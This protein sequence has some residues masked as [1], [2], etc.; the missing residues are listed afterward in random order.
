VHTNV[1]ARLHT[2]G[3][4]CFSEAS[5][6]QYQMV[7]ERL[8]AAL[9]G[10]FALVALVLPGMGL[11]GVL[12]Y[13]VIQRRHQIAF[14]SRWALVPV[15][16]SAVSITTNLFVMISLGAIIGL[17]GELAC[18]R[19]VDTLLFEV[20][21]TD[22]GIVLGSIIFYRRGLPLLSGS[23]MR[24]TPFRNESARIEPLGQESCQ[25]AYR[26]ATR[27]GG[28]PKKPPAF[29][30]RSRHSAATQRHQADYAACDPSHRDAHYNSC[31]RRTHDARA[32]LTLNKS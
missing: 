32:G 3:V 29:M 28:S 1:R 26:C 15:T 22:P 8:L 5:V 31:A 11:Y 2:A 7:R 14:A 30:W 4:E 13:A 12:R 24:Y 18:G 6:I 27:F 23:G 10:F 17:A 16:W 19:L 20:K 25:R 21:P 9:S